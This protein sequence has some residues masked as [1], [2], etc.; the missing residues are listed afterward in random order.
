[1]LTPKRA[2]QTMIIAMQTASSNYTQGVSNFFTY[3]VEKA[4]LTITAVDTTRFYR[5]EN[6]EFTFAYEGFV[7]GDDETSLASLPVAGM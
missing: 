2:G 4:P 5:E 6:P 7:A 1:M 3:V